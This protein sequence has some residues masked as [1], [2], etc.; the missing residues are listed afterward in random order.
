MGCDIHAIIERKRPDGSYSWWINAGDPDIDRS[1][2][3]FSVLAGVRNDLN[4]KPIAEPR[5]L[6]EDV[7]SIMRDW[8]VDYGGHSPSYVTLKEM[9]NFDLDQTIYDPHLIISRD[10]DGKITGTCGA[11]NGKH[12]GPVGE[13]KIFGLWGREY[14]QEL[15]AQ[16]EAVKRPGQTDDDVRLVFFFDN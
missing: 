14:W 4:I 8:F 11:T 3:L 16:L 5:G 13:R 1:Y 2:E 15:I 7:T 12:E 10:K 9:K 6:P